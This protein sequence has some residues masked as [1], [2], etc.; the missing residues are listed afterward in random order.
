MHNSEVSRK[1]SRNIRL[2]GILLMILAAML[3]I[4]FIAILTNEII[5]D[6]Q[7]NN[8]R[9]LYLIPLS[10]A[11]ICILVIFKNK[12]ETQK[13]TKSLLASVKLV[14]PD[15]KDAKN[16]IEV[17]N[18]LQ[19]KKSA[20]YLENKINALKED[21][22]IQ[23]KEK[24]KEILKLEK[25]A[26][27]SDEMVNNFLSNVSHE[28][29]TPLTV[30]TGFADIL[31]SRS[32]NLHEK[33]L[34]QLKMII[35]S[36]HQLLRLINDLLDLVRLDSGQ[37]EFLFHYFELAN[38]IEIA[39]E[40]CYE[41]SNAENFQFIIDISRNVP[42]KVYSDEAVVMHILEKLIS[43]AIKFTLQG[44][45]KSI[46]IFV[47][48]VDKSGE[49]YISVKNTGI[50]IPSEKVKE[51][52]ESFKQIDGSSTRKYGGVGIGLALCKKLILHLKGDIYV[53]NPSEGGTV[54]TFCFPALKKFYENKS[55]KSQETITTKANK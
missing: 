20:V 3:L 48:F 38:C 43:N 32:D 36:G 5:L 55:N 50:G 39:K 54:L 33:Q 37:Y 26:R 14:N 21:F 24:N 49:I 4:L 30:I 13:L 19:E 27:L 12:F 34:I 15:L 18:T 9:I 31:L 10:I 22:H 11:L 41:N 25:Q 40:H 8:F 35:K 28:L 29:R 42:E 51:I 7:N 6:T 53:E 45:E 52:F 2:N 46:Y 47:R 1:I 17:V 16:L 23:L 44:D